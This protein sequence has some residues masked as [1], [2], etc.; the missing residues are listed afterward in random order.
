MNEK[1]DKYDKDTGE[2]KHNDNRLPVANTGYT[3]AKL[4]FVV[5]IVYVEQP[6]FD[7]SSAD[8]VVDLF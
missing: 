4:F 6:L 5:N 3:S 8:S 7:R 1:P 2:R